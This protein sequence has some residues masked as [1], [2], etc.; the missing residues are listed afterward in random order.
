ME[1]L[2]SLL[3]ICDW[4]SAILVCKKWYRIGIS[5]YVIQKV[6]NLPT[7]KDLIAQTNKKYILYSDYFNHSPRIYKTY[8]GTIYF[9]SSLLVD[10]KR[11]IGDVIVSHIGIDK[12]TGINK[13]GVISLIKYYK[14]SDFLKYIEEEFVDSDRKYI[15]IVD[16]ILIGTCLLAGYFI[17]KAIKNR[18]K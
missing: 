8:L 16:Y 7:Y 13:N 2:F 10:K 5:N 4:H 9:K 11:I 15:N 12:H 18:M 17:G 14:D 3:E 1:Y 6:F